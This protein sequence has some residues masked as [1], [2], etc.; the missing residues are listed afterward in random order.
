MRAQSKAGHYRRTAYTAS[1]L[2]VAMS[3]MPGLASAADGMFTLKIENDGLASSDDGHFTSGVEFNWSFAPE[4]D[5]WSQRLA[6]ALPESLIG[7]ADRVAYR[8][9]HQI[10]T[11]DN[12]RVSE[13]IED[14]RPY[15]GLVL[16]GISLYED[17][18]RGDWRQATDLHFDV[19]LVGP[20]SLADSL[21]R[22]VHRVTN[23]DH[24]NGWDNQLGDEPIL[25]A[26]FRRQ[27]WQQLPLAGKTFSH[28]PSVGAALGNLYVYANG[29]YGVRW[30]DE[31]T[32]LPSMTPNPGM[33]QTFS[34]DN[35]FRWY[36]FASV[37]GYYM[38]HNLTLDG[39]TF[40]NSH[41]VDRREWVGDVMGGVA[42]AWDAWQMTY[43][44]VSRTREFHGQEESDSFGM[45]TL[46][47]T[48]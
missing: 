27:W 43:T 12:I 8:L 5:H 16:G 2:A 31:G 23:S 4:E 39:N 7:R 41:S 32:G 22:E 28:G 18:E 37:D 10:Y 19:G 30:G 6:T 38:A 44:A 11:P 13:L 3:L 47:R 29:G 34:Q 35:G 21:Q 1:A 24:P 45:I 20:S 17:V 25:S 14:D 15:A 36:L 26:A 9:T 42:L 33:R 48:F 46:A 40:K